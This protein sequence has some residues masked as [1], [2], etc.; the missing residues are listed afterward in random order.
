M[1][2]LRRGHRGEGKALSP[3]PPVADLEIVSSSAGDD[4][5]PHRSI[6]HGVGCFWIVNILDDGP[7]AESQTVL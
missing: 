5:H 7:A 2:I 6:D 1:P 4:A 3:L